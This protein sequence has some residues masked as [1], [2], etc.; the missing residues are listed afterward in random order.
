[1]LVVDNFS[2]STRHNVIDLLAARFELMRPRRD[3]P[4]YVE[5]DQTTTACP[6]RR[7]S[8]GDPVQTTK[9]WCHGSI[10]MLGRGPRLV[11]EILLGLN[12]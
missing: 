3:V 8:T 11:R 10:N 1:V 9:D 4:I 6:A 5:V 7:P 2:S 12:V